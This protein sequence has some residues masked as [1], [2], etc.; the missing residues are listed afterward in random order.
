MEANQLE[1]ESPGPTIAS[2]VVAPKAM[3][4]FFAYFV[5]VGRMGRGMWV[6]CHVINILGCALLF[7]GFGSVYQMSLV[8]D[9]VFAALFYCLWLYLYFVI[10]AKRFHDMGY[11]AWASLIGFVPVVPIFML[12]F[13]GTKGPNEYGPE[14]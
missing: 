5:P 4:P 7:V 12:I 3:H 9:R 2:E 13:P 8:E 6:V 14:P 10:G 11:P 1:S